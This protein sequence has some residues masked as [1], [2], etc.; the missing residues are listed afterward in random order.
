MPVRNFGPSSSN[1][2]PSPKFSEYPARLGAL[3][4]D[5]AVTPLAQIPFNQGSNLRLLE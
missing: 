2:T 3:N 1:F 4:L 5:I